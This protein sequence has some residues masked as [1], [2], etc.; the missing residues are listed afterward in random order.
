MH[1]HIIN[2]IA[3]YTEPYYSAT[4]I[5]DLIP[6]IIANALRFMPFKHMGKPLAIVY[7]PIDLLTFKNRLGGAIYNKDFDSLDNIILNFFTTYACYTPT[8]IPMHLKFTT[9]ATLNFEN[10]CNT[11]KGMQWNEIVYKFSS[12][13]C[14]LLSTGYINNGN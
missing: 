2:S 3:Y 10:T 4:Q 9:E 6:D 5:A 14:D 13:L 11:F 1:K 7:T 8:Y 12:A